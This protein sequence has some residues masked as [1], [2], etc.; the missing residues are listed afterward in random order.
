VNA[1]DI[2][3]AKNA[4]VFP[5]RFILFSPSPFHHHFCGFFLSESVRNA[6]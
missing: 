4:K 2:I 3:S 1:A 5:T 6:A